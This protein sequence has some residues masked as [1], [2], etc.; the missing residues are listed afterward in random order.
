[1]TETE[2]N[3]LSVYIALSVG[4]GF[5]GMEL[6]L[7]VCVGECMGWGKPILYSISKSVCEC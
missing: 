5:G 6:S 7:R 1:M 4:G 3:A 2:R